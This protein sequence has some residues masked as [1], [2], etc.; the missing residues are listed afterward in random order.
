MITWT[1]DPSSVTPRVEDWTIVERESCGPLIVASTLDGGTHRVIARLPAYY[2]QEKSEV[3]ANARL[4]AA[5]P[6]MLAA[7]K[8]LLA[9]INHAGSDVLYWV[10]EAEANARAAIALAEGKSP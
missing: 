9:A 6:S 4:I 2:K 1:R 8:A 3:L 10:E 5:S 7:L